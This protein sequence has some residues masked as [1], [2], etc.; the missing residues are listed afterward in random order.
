[1]SSE[2]LTFIATFIGAIATWML[3][4]YNILD[5]LKRSKLNVTGKWHG[6]SV[7]IPLEGSFYEDHEAIYKIEAE[8]K[9]VGRR[10]WIT[11]I[12]KDI[13]NIYGDRLEDLP[14]REVIG[15]GMMVGDADIT[16]RFS[17]KDSLTPGAMYLVL[18]TW[19]DEL[20]GVLAVK[21][22]TIGKPVAVRIL[23]RRIEKRMPSLKELGIARI[24]NLVKPLLTHVAEDHRLTSG[25]DA[26][27]QSLHVPESNDP[28]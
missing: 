13:Y 3:D 25:R 24:R 5:M 12:L 4:R 17:E 27:G 23:L 8:F 14:P 10:I 11:E 19:G 20:R 2:L 7:Y 18:N 22:P 9:Q 6:W 21:S 28:N 26:S 1:M 16:L 15:S